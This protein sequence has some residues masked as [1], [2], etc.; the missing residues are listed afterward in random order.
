MRKFR[1]AAK[2]A[3]LDVKLLR[4]RSNLRIDDGGV[5][6]RTRSREHFRLSDRIG[7]MVRRAN[8]LS[9]LIFVGIRY[10]QQNAT[11][12]RPSHLIFRR[13]IRAAKKWLSI[14]QQKSG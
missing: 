4:D 13:K 2:A 3:I 7:Q 12:A 8:K 9:S 11:E 1:R 5:E 10:R 6:L 14:R